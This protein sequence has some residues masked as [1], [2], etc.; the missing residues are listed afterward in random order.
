MTI[1]DLIDFANTNH[2]P[3]DTKLSVSGADVAAV[4]FFEKDGYLVLDD[5]ADMAELF[6]ASQDDLETD[7]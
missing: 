4:F 6:P 7:Q 2:I 1:Q 3:R 5:S